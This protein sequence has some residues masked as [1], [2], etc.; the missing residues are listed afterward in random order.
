[1]LLGTS[2]NLRGAEQQ[3]IFET[4]EG[5]PAAKSPDATGIL[6]R[7][8]ALLKHLQ[9]DTATAH[10]LEPRQVLQGH[11]EIPAPFGILRGKPATNK[12]GREEGSHGSVQKR[13][14]WNSGTQEWEESQNGD[15]VF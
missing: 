7:I 1:M 4:V 5:H 15:D 6:L 2:P 14:I 12:D 9:P 13:I 11:G 8:A 10:P 3:A